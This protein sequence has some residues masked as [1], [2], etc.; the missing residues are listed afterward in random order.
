MLPSIGKYGFTNRVQPLKLPLSV[1]FRRPDS[2]VQSARGIAYFPVA[3]A[4]FARCVLP[5]LPQ[6]K[7]AA[8]HT[9]K[10]L[11]WSRAQ[12]VVWR[13]WRVPAWLRTYLY[14]CIDP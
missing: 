7:T 5:E 2:G 6:L 13:S 3:A 9:A 11:R 8:H 1:V 14:E 10:N 4:L 12:P